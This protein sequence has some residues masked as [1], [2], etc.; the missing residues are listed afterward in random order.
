MIHQIPLSSRQPSAASHLPLT[1]ISL[2]DW[3]L[4]ILKKTDTAKYLQGQVTADIST[5]CA[6]QHVLCGHCDYK[7]RMWSTLRLFHYGDGYA[8][9]ERRSVLNNQLTEIKKYAIF[10]KITIKVNKHAILLGVAGLQA[11]GV[12]SNI[13]KILPDAK[14]QVIEKDNTVLLHFTEP[15]ERFLLVTTTATAKNLVAKLYNQAD[16]KDSRQWLTL[17]IEAGYPIIDK[18]N[19]AQFIPQATNLQALNGISFNKGCYSGQEMVACAQFR[20]ANK[21]ALYWLEGIAQRTPQAAEELELKL[22][23]TW[24]R[25]GKV[26][27]ASTLVDGTLWIQAVMNNDLSA[28]SKIRVHNDVTS[29]LTIKP[30]PYKVKS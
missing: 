16:F 17:E 9:L 8:Y 21:K 24:R 10:S 12:L 25:T 22:G 26:L 14:H 29:K 1:I 15:A 19:S 13:F 4:V 18:N 6:D 28:N 30:L 5:L 7:G 3:A 27:A 2:E 11:R 20:G 23:D